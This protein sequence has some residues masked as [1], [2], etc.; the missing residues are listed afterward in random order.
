MKTYNVEKDWI[1]KAGLRAVVV[2]S[3]KHYSTHRCGYVALP[4]G[5]KF[6]GVEYDDIPAEVH[7]GLTYSRVADG[8]PVETESPVY[9]IG[10]DCGHYMDD[11]DGGR[12]LDYCISECES[13]AEQVK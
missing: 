8:Y 5:N 7:G 10:Y 11:E 13:L 1:T 4:E 9:W 6:F 12:S 3:T 2:R